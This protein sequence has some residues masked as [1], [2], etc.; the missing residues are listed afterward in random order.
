[1]SLSRWYIGWVLLFP[2]MEKGSI[3]VKY[4]APLEKEFK[5]PQ[6]E[7]IDNMVALGWPREAAE[8]QWDKDHPKS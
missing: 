5:P 4:K 7:W 1:M 8:K 2:A 6:I 3:K